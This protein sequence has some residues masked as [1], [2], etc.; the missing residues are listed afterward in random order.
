MKSRILLLCL[1]LLPVLATA[2][3][4]KWRDTNGVIRYSDV[5]PPSN[6]KQEPMH[7]KK[8]VKPTG[9]APLAEVEGDATVA[10]N[11][12]KAA[13]D[14]AKAD[15]LKKAPPTKEEAAAKRAKEAEESKKQEAQKKAELEIKQE[16]CK[17]AKSRLATYTN[18][19]RITKT[20]E[21]GQKVFLGDADIAKARVEAQSDVDT[22]CN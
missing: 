13:D 14:K 4:Y 10:I 17:N 18:G 21:N 1:M 12:L 5:P 20:D 9:Q 11:K 8:L 3:I 15:D 2:E 16:N 19:G 22:H 7:G 6:I